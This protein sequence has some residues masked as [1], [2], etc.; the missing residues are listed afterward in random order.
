MNK[1]RILLLGT[2]ESG[3]TTLFNQAR[4][5]M[6]AGYPPELAARMRSVLIANVIVGAKTILD[7][8][9]MFDRTFTDPQAQSAADLVLNAEATN[10][11]SED[12]AHAIITLWDDED[13][14]AIW[15]QRSNFQLQD[16]WDELAEKLRAYPAWGGP[17]WTPSQEDLLQCRTHSIG[18][19]EE[20]FLRSKWGV[21]V[22]LIDVGGLRGERRK[23][24]PYF[25][26]VDLII[27]VVSISEYDQV[28]AEDQTKNRLQESLELF[29]EIANAKWSSKSNIL[30]LFNKVDVLRDKLLS[31]HIPLNVSGLFADAPKCNGYQ[32][33]PEK[34]ERFLSNA[35]RWFHT[36]F[37]AECRDTK[38]VLVQ[39]A[40]AVHTEQVDNIF[41]VV[42]EIILRRNLHGSRYLR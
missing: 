15:D 32:N 4:I 35:I 25:E 31:Q 18:I 17:D 20:E 29:N 10:D 16:D 42:G 12:L 6:G 40:S 14:R 9:D 19:E 3:K 28:L 39:V 27:F 22:R 41:R 24:T 2:S 38:F 37:L 21:K 7:A 11:L 36:R 26:G 30:I 1:F 33:D 8:A 23:W 13:F 34:A 5:V